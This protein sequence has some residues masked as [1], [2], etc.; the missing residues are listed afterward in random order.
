MKGGG[1][2]NMNI[3]NSEHNNLSKNNNNILAIN[4][5]FQPTAATISSPMK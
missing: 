3:P 4:S 2:N 1:S 5:R